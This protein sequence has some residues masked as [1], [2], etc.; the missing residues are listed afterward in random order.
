Q[1]N[2]LER[3]AKAFDPRLQ[4]LMLAAIAQL[5]P[6]V[7]GDSSIVALRRRELSFTA[8]GTRLLAENH[9]LSKELTDSVSKLV[10]SSRTEISSATA[11]CSARRP[12]EHRGSHRRCDAKPHQLCSHR[13]ALR[14]ARYNRAA[15]RT[16]R[17]HAYPGSRRSPVPSAARRQRRNRPHGGIARPI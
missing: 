16:Q 5:R 11:R 3:L 14:R 1:V 15:Y 2:E 7:S 4:S 17:T 6:F 9:A 10:A 8:N 13:L 12:T